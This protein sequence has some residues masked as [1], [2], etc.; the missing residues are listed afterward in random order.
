V[1]KHHAMMTNRGVEIKLSSLTMA[2]YEG[3]QL[4][5]RWPVNHGTFCIQSGAC[6]E[7]VAKN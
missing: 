7:A 5:S 6:L 3:V 4:V 1:L 2:M